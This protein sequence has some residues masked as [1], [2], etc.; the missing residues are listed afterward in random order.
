[1]GLQG[2]SDAEEFAKENTKNVAAL[3][4]GLTA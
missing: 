4:V 1:V 2:K 3:K